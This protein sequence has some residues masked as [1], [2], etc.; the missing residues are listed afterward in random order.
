M[1][2]VDG[3][4]LPV[5]TARLGEYKKIAT[6]AGK[7]WIEHGAL[8]YCECAGDDLNPGWGVPFP[9][10]MKMKEGETAVFA[11]VVYK[12]KADRKRVNAKVM[13]DERLAKMMDPKD[14]IFDMKRMVYGGFTTLVD[15]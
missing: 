2:Y 10:P 9:K 15:L 12:S 4:L 3:Y 1:R 7:I 5:P 6:K 14:P 8:Q 11:F 13:K